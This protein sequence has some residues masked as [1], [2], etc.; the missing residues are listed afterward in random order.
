MTK[1]L[2]AFVLA[3]VPA[4]ALG[5]SGPVLESSQVNINDIASMQRGAS[6][7]MNYCAGCHSL[8]FQRYSRM[9]KDLD[10]TEEEVVQ[11]LMF[12][13]AK[14]GEP[15]MAAMTVAEG[16]KWF[17]KAPPDL[18]LVARNKLGGPD[19]TYTYLKSFYADESRPSGWN[20]TVLVGSSMPHVLWELQGIQ[21]P[22]LTAE[23]HVERLELATPGSQTAAE[24][25]QTLRDLANFL[26]YV[27]EPSAA[28][29][30]SIG[31]GVLAFLAV[32]TLLAWLL[33]KEYWKDV[34]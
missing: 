16:E 32:F 27:G 9:A 17:G 14:F 10:L 7:Y 29:R 15:I 8:G 6:L 13:D 5:A 12:T 11:N 26:T 21:R 18:S 1:R 31:V 25:D 23:G 19:W 34:H 33:K 22:V 20:N 3:F 30:R 4:V 2:M 28:K 24:Y